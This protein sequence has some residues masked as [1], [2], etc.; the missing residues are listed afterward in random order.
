MKIIRFVLISLLGLS[1]SN[2]NAQT[3]VGLIQNNGNTISDGYT[4]FSPMSSF[5]S[6]LIDRCGKQVKTWTSTY[7]PALGSYLMDDGSLIRTGNTMNTFFNAGGRGGAIQKYDWNGNLVWS[8]ILSDSLNCPHHDICPLPNGN[9]LVIAWE[10]KNSATAIANGR[11]PSLVTPKLWSEQILEIQPVGSNGGNIVWEW[12]L[13]DHLVQEFDSTKANYGSVE[14]APQLVNINFNASATNADW[15]HLN[16]VDYNPTLDQIVLSNHAFGEIW[17][18]DHSTTTAQAASHAGGNAGRGGDLLY[19]WGNPSAYNAAGAQQFFGQHNAHWIKPGLPYENQIMVFNNG[20][21]R[22]GGNY[23]TIEIIN[24]P[25]SGYNYNASL[26]YLPAAPTWKYNNMN[27]HNLFAQNISGAQQLANGNVIYT[28]GPSGSFVEIDSIGNKLWEYVNPI[29]STGPLTQG[30]TP[31]TNAVFHC[32]FYPTNFSGF[33]GKTLTATT[34]LENVN[35]ISDSCS[36]TSGLF[37]QE[38]NLKIFLYPN[39]AS[40]KIK[41]Q[42]P[43]TITNSTILEVYNSIGMVVKKVVIESWKN[44]SF[45]LDVNDLSNGN[46]YLRLIN[47]QNNYYQQMVIVK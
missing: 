11:N 38:E 24:P 30:T 23:S 34:I 8:Y 26:P 10:V 40:D 31:S 36:L 41:V 5:N 28:D 17:I 44:N 43:S 15:I 7:R 18:I 2:V 45:E 3:T 22:P 13:W 9:I 47:Q 12:H 1:I 42:L 37:S 4:L 33:V 35:V 29:I 6:Y 46:Y 32:N 14:S 21:A 27:V 16:A 39:P 20:I 19:R 25:L